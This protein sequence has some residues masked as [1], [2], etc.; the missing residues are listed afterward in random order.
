MRLYRPGLRQC[1]ASVTLHLKSISDAYLVPSTDPEVEEGEIEEDATPQ[2]KSA[3]RRFSGPVT[4]SKV[5]DE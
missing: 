1:Q 3:G 2:A 5:V 4:I